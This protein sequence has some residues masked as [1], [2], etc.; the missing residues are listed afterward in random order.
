M[1]TSIKR[2]VRIQLNRSCIQYP[3]CLLCID[4]IQYNTQLLFNDHSR[5]PGFQDSFSLT[6]EV[7]ENRTE[8]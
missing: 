2:L 3:F 4:E 1:I 7:K 5:F 8:E 6:E